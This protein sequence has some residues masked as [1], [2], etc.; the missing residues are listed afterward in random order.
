MDFEV[1]VDHRHWV[2]AHFA[3]SDGVVDG[4]GFAADEIDGF[5]FSLNRC[6]REDK[7]IA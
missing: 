4:F 7:A 6:L 2:I 3:S 5:S 1:C